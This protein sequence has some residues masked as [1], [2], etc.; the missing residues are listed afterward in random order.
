VFV[1]SESSKCHKCGAE[2]DG[3]GSVAH[4][5]FPLG[6]YVWECGGCFEKEQIRQSALKS[7]PDVIGKLKQDGIKEQEIQEHLNRLYRR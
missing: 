1:A 4:S 3:S 6:G 5:V 7:L 2:F